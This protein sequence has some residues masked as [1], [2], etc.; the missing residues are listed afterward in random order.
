MP[1]LHD[2]FGVLLGLMP[3]GV[4]INMPTTGPRINPVN[5]DLVGSWIRASTSTMSGSAGTTYAAGVGASVR[6]ETGVVLDGHRVRGR[7]YLVPLVSAIF[8]A[9]GT[10]M[11]SQQALILNAA[12]ATV[13]AMGTN[14]QVWHRPS[15]TGTPHVGSA[16]PVTTAAV[17]DRPAILRSRRS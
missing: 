9:D 12:L 4:T 15:T 10:L 14:M 16:V 6:W 2:F 8:D 5:G 1:P 3:A 17:P 13:T 7:T 11:F